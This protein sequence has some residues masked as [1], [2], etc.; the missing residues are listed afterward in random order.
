MSSIVEIDLNLFGTPL[1]ELNKRKKPIFYQFSIEEIKNILLHSKSYKEVS[2][3]F[4]Y[5]DNNGIISKNID[6]I[7]KKINIKLPFKRKKDC[8]KLELTGQTFGEL[9]VIKKDEKR[10]QQSGHSYWFVKCSCG[11]IKEKSVLASNLKSGKIQSCGHLRGEHFKGP[12]KGETLIEN[13]FINNNLKYFK[14]YKIEL[15]DETTN[16][17]LQLWFD[18]QVITKNNDIYYIE[19]NGEQHYK[20]V[21]FFGGEEK[22]KRQKHYD[23]LKIEYCKK[24]NINLIIIPYNEINNISKILEVLL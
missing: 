5:K 11:K 22:F 17:E 18:F 8:E 1:E 10:T 15:F 2:Q 20:P 24:N 16:K 14:E 7:A 19:F 21:E 6:N 12:S 13:F 23:Q 4:G 9:T 3:K